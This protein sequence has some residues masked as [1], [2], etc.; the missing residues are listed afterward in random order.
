MADSHGCAALELRRA[1]T[2]LNTLWDQHAADPGQQALLCAR[3]C[4]ESAP[5]LTEWLKARIYASLPD[6]VLTQ[7]L[8][9]RP[10]DGRIQA[11]N[12][13]SQQDKPAA[14]EPV[15]IPQKITRN[16]HS[17]EAALPGA[18]QE[19]Y[20]ALFAIK[21]KVIADRSDREFRLD[22][23]MGRLSVALSL[24]HQYRFYVVARQLCRDE[25][26]S[27]RVLKSEL[28]DQLTYCDVSYTQRHFNRLLSAG[29]GVF[30]NSDKKNPDAIYLH[31]WK[32]VGLRLVGL[33]EEQGGEIGFNR[34]GVL[35]Y[36]VDVSGSLEVWEARL[37]ASWIAR[38][39]GDRDGLSISR[40]R[41]SALF[42]RAP[43]TIRRWERAH[44]KKT[45]G[46]RFDYEQHPDDLR[47]PDEL[48]DLQGYV[49]AHAN[50]YQALAPSGCVT[51]RRWQR[52]NTYTSGIRSHS[53]N[54]QARK[55]RRVVNSAISAET[56]GGPWRLYYTP[57][58][59]LKR[60]KS[61]RF[62]SGADGDV[63]E[64]VHVFIGCDRNKR[65]VWELMLPDPSYPHPQTSACERVMVR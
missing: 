38:R 30:W 15:R 55:V 28:R 2:Q 61:F 37:Y 31:S 44:L 60:M 1:Q 9:N 29:E 63:C 58:A 3:F 8:F 42:G 16:W 5:H 64:P 19:T 6:A 40:E 36:L 65:G 48:Y 10:D 14:P 35:Q 62:R 13:L 20:Q 59:H 18:P 39:A 57:A 47:T 22:P 32:R 24:A 25:G 11:L 54:G 33:A 34:P 17:L 21:P 50:P 53:N 46:V 23:E 49:P 51:R 52:V 27:G 7:L 4:L 43:K 56:D 41:L 12:L 45:V 26:G